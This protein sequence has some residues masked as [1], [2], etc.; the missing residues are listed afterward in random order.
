MYTLP[1][2]VLLL[3]WRASALPRWLLLPTL[4]HQRHRLPFRHLWRRVRPRLC[5]MFWQLHRCARALLSRGLHVTFGVGCVPRWIFLQRQR[6]SA[7][8]VHLC[9]RL[10]LPSRSSS[11]YWTNLPHWRFLRRGQRG[12]RF[13]RPRDCLLR[14]GAGRAAA[15]LLER[16]HA[17]RQWGRG[18]GRW[19]GY[20]SG[21]Q[22]PPWC[23][24]GPFNA[25][26]IRGRFEQ[27]PRESYFFLRACEH[28]RRLGECGICKWSWRLRLL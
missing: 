7:R 24:C 16:E 11:A 18:V 26:L 5:L 27:S 14:A 21:V 19:A 3:L 4:I 17:G 28:P 9:T 23:V 1:C 12:K 15:V 10:L 8:T 6:C 2:L 20:S 22:Y 13:L 25:E